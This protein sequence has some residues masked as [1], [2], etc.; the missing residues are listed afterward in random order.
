VFSLGFELSVQHGGLMVDSLRPLVPAKM[1]A[2]T[3]KELNELFAKL[4]IS[5]DRTDAQLAATDRQLAKTMA[6]VEKVSKQIGGIGRNQG[7]ITEEFFY[8]SLN[9]NPVVGG[10]KFDRVTPN[11]IVGTKKRQSEFDIVLTNGSSV[12]IVE[13]K[14]KAHASDLDQ[15]EA[16]IKRYR[17]LCPE[18]KGY[19]LYGGIAGF[20]VPPD[21]VKAAHERGIFVLKRKG[22]VLTTDANV[23]RAF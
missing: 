16:Q 23:M 19:K 10:I 8:N 18:F 6:T 9:A 13:V 7:D 11:L 22:D 14:N 3:N 17:E 21:V 15:V 20:S 5:Q 2:M 12:A 4:A 1:T